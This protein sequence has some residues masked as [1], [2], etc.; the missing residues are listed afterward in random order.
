M[1]TNLINKQDEL[2]PDGLEVLCYNEHTDEYNIGAYHDGFSGKYWDT[3]IACIDVTH[4]TYL[5]YRNDTI[6]PELLI[7]NGYNEKDCTMLNDEFCKEFWYTKEVYFGCHITIVFKG[8][9]FTT[10]IYFKDFSLCINAKTMTQF[11]DLYSLIY[12]ASTETIDNFKERYG[13]R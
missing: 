6:T 10:H 9:T 1:I 11:K 13:E 8:V 12:E 7:L 2:P 5:R 3:N 4:W